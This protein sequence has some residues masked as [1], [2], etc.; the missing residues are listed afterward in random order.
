MVTGL[1]QISPV[2]NNVADA[3]QNLLSGVS[4]IGRITRF[5]AGELSA[6]IA[7]EV[8]GFQIGDY[9]GAKEARR[10]DAFIH[11]GIAAALQAVCLPLKKPAS[12]CT[13]TARAA[14]TPSLFPDR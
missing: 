4:G 8:K 14:S 7:G 11:Y 2:G 3:W 5:D 6:Q 13:K 12:W 9:I 10:M 1:G